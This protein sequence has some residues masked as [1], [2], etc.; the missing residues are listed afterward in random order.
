M[1]RRLAMALPS[2]RCLPDGGR[3]AVRSEVGLSGSS[4]SRIES[5]TSSFWPCDRSVPIQICGRLHDWGY[6]SPTL[7]P[8]SIRVNKLHVRT[9][10]RPGH[11]GR[12]QHS[13][14]YPQVE[15]THPCGFPRVGNGP[16]HDVSRSRAPVS[17][18]SGMAR[19]TPTAR[20]PARLLERGR[21]SKLL[22]RIW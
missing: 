14:R 18:E 16:Q 4:T 5:A 11:F 3:S 13:W 9:G 2:G 21:L 22:P 10:A 7:I 19:S 17:A 20:I 8:E 1:R 12:P 15:F 6:R